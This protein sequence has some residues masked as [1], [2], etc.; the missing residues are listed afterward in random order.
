M[1]HFCRYFDD[2]FEA[3]A[4]RCYKCGGSGHMARDCVEEG[5]Q[6]PCYLCAQFGHGSVVCPARL[7]FRCSRPGHMARECPNGYS[8]WL[9]CHAFYI[10]RDR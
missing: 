6:R 7:C 3:A 9:P 8:R 5:R 10:D 1:N 2:D 4:T